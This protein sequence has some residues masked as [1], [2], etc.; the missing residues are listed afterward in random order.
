MNGPIPPIW[1]TATTES[2]RTGTWRAAL[3][4][5]VQAPSPCHAACPVNGD[6][7]SW[8]GLAR[9]GDYRGAWDVLVRH[10][11]FPAIAG[12][13]CHHPCERACNR[14][15]FDEALSI[16]KLERF[17]GDHAIAAGWTFDPPVEQ[18][19]E[20]VAVVGGGPAG[21]SAA[22]QLRRLGYGVTIVEARGALGGLM[23]HGIPSYRLSRAVL[24]AEIARIVALGVTVRLDTTL[25]TSQAWDELARRARR[26]VRGHRGASAEAPPV[27]RL[28]RAV[29]GRRGVVPACGQRGPPAV[30][31]PSRGGRRRRQCRT[32]CRAQRPP[33]RP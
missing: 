33:R 9:D 8:I 15:G 19:R 4:R 27:A 10:N 25:D 32:G 18:R 22:Y 13:I 7:A 31:R 21:L 26:A 23:R 20:R 16:C 24:D 30:A 29:G 6:I 5:H 1:T 11:P 12:R 2:I 17:V 3:P 14:A 28:R